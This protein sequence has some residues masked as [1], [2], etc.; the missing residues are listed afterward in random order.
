[1]SSMSKNRD[2]KTL[3]LLNR[4]KIYRKDNN[5]KFIKLDDEDNQISTPISLKIESIDEIYILNK[6][7]LDSETLAF[8]ANKNV[9]IH[10]F[11]SNQTFKGNFFPNTTNSISKSSF[12]FIKQLEAFKNEKRLII[13]KEITKGHIH[14]A[15]FNLK[16]YKI[17]HDLNQQTLFESIDKSQSINELM[18]VEGSFQKRYYQN[19]NQIIKNQRSFKFTT[20][21]K[22]PPLDKLNSFISYLNTRIYNI[23]LAEIYKTQLDPRISYLHEPNDKSVALHLDIAEIFKPIIADNL[24]FS[25]LNYQEI[26]T[27]SFD[28]KNG[29]IRFKQEDLQ[30]LEK[31]VILK[32]YETVE[33]NNKKYTFRELIRREANQIKKYLV[34]N[35]IYSSFKA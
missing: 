7:Y 3:F 22:R 2:D 28:V 24:I 16:K 34:E 23:C 9:L 30:K 35:I 8:I 20:R 12:V 29:L 15:I 27:K 17:E 14:N 6:I 18:G 10:F 1:M 32:L 5:L 33:I 11:N 4:G 13:A 19:F 25:M 21:S 26:T 31:R